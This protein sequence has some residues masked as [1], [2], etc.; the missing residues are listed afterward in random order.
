MDMIL[1]IPVNDLSR[2]REFGWRMLAA[3]TIFHSLF[4]AKASEN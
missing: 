2:A 1:D 4:S 3:E